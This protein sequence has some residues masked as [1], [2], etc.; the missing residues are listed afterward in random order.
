MTTAACKTGLHRLSL[1]V[2]E[3][4]I[5]GSVWGAGRGVSLS[6]KVRHSHCGRKKHWR[7]WRLSKRCSTAEEVSSDDQMNLNKKAEKKCGRRQESKANLAHCGA[8]AERGNGEK[9]YCFT[10]FEP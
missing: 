5:R 2:E 4:I 10:E 8:P 9:S 3:R 1:K 6:I 7:V